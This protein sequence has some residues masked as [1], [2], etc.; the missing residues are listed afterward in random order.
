MNKQALAQQLLAEIHAQLDQC[1]EDET[2]TFTPKVCSFISQPEGKEK[3]VQW[4]I[5]YVVKEK[6]SVAEAINE[7]ERDFNDNLMES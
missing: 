6:M 4:I 1:L 7:I 3:A 5:N 2:G